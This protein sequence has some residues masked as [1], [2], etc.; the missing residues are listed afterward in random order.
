MRFV[1]QVHHS[2]SVALPCR[3]CVGQADGRVVNN[4][5]SNL[6]RLRDEDSIGLFGELFEPSHASFNESHCRID[7]AIACI[8]KAFALP[9][10][11]SA[12]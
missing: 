10:R 8:A 4:S 6:Q 2:M 5:V 9:N 11:V 12:P 3:L 7:E 1:L